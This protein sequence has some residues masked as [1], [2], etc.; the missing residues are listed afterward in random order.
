MENPKG[1]FCENW[2]GISRFLL[3]PKNVF[4]VALAVIQ[5]GGAEKTNYLIDEMTLFRACVCG[6]VVD[7]Y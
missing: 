4:A 5:R 6:V 3:S 2:F 1:A 7:S